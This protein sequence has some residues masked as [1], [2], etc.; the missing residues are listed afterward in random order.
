MACLAAGL[1]L[2]PTPASAQSAAQSVQAEVD[3]PCFD[4]FHRYVDCGNGTVTDTVTGL[5]WLKD[6]ACLGKADW[7]QG[8]SLAA[9]LGDGACRLRD[10]S[11]GTACLADGPSS[12]SGVE[13]SEYWSLTTND[14]HPNNAWVATL[15]GTLDG[16]VFPAVK[17]FVLPVWPVR[18]P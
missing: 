4:N 10:G 16:F 6:A 9:E 7:A 5:I 8:T 3:P 15:V 14:Q 1:W 18:R 12:F 13:A 17:T 2:V 11:S